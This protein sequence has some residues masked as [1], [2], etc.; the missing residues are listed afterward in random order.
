MTFS[1]DKSV[2]AH[3]KYIRNQKLLEDHQIVAYKTSAWPKCYI[4]PTEMIVG[5]HKWSFRTSI[6]N[7]K[8]TNECKYLQ[9]LMGD[10]I[11]SIH[12][13]ESIKNCIYLS[14]FFF[15]WIHKITNF[16]C[17]SCD[18]LYQR[19]YFHKLILWTHFSTQKNNKHAFPL[20]NDI[21][22]LDRN[23]QNPH[24][25]ILRTKRVWISKLISNLISNVL[26]QKKNQR[27][28]AERKLYST[29]FKCPAKIA[30]IVG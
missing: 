3:G 17:N 12:R 20:S 19:V 13:I 16:L 25:N 10:S 24:P 15:S 2:N 30:R 23:C 11:S 6:K 9:K 28:N 22:R 7:T 5:D 1:R 14:F 4:P 27:M 18:I 21:V 29:K 8:M 26:V